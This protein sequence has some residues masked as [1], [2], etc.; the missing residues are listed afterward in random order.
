MRFAENARD[1]QASAENIRSHEEVIRTHEQNIKAT[2]HE[3]QEITQKFSKLADYDVR[4]SINVYFPS[5]SAKLSEAAKKDLMQLARSAAPL[6][7]YLIEVEGYADASGSAD[8]NQQAKH[9][10]RFVRHR[11]FA[12]RGQHSSATSAYAGSYGRVSSCILEHVGA[13]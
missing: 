11:I 7:S 4:Y 12:T 5:G 2:L 10:A 3:I 6:H 1:I 9:A 13:G 8:Q